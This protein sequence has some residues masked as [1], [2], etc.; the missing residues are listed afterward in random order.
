MQMRSTM[1]RLE[2][3]LI[4]AVTFYGMAAMAG[5]VVGDDEAAKSAAQNAP[6]MRV[7]P[8]TTQ[9]A[10]AKNRTARKNASIDDIDEVAAPAGKKFVL[11]CWQNGMLIVERQV[12]DVPPESSKA[13]PLDGGRDA[14]KELG[15]HGGNRGGMR[16]FDL[17]NATCLLQ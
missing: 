2:L 12:D 8:S 10:P 7:V 5:V 13:V 6:L 17:R 1:K 4:C 14:A 3:V 15:N 9:P 11:R 16:L